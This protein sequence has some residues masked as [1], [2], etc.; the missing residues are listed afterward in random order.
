VNA[1]EAKRLAT[2]IVCDDLTRSLD[3]SDEWARHPETD[4][5]LTTEESTKVRAQG[6]KLA[7]E[8]EARIDR[9]S[10][11]RMSARFRCSTT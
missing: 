5:E 6:R 11:G 9:L 7:D 3:V 8:L 2:V 4:A 1:R 10:Q